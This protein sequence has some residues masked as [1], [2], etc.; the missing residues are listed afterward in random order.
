MTNVIKILLLL[1]VATFSS[2][3]E[4]S[5]KEEVKKENFDDFFNKFKNNKDFQF[6]RIKSPLEYWSYKSERV[7]ENSTL[8][9][10]SLD[11]DKL[12]YNSFDFKSKTKSTITNTDDTTVYKVR[13]VESAIHLNYYFA[14]DKNKWFLVKIENASN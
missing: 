10:R 7:E 9:R 6:A 2:C 3:N 1:V 13:G 11:K 12:R 8:T 14:M 4:R 5:S